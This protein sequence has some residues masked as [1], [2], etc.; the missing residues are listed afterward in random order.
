LICFVAWFQ[1]GRQGQDACA[2]GLKAGNGANLHIHEKTGKPSPNFTTMNLNA[3][4]KQHG[5]GPEWFDQGIA[6]MSSA[7]LN[8]KAA[9]AQIAKIPFPLSSHIARVFKP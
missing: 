6:N 1:H 3:G 8:R 5:S 2:E 9:S 7:G 4:V